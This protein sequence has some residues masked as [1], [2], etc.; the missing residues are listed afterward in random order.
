[1]VK[2]VIQQ[3]QVAEQSRSL[4]SLAHQ[5]AWRDRPQIAPG[6]DNA[7]ALQQPEVAAPVQV[8]SAVICTREHGKPE[9]CAADVR[10]VR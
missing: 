2:S 4:R 9:S 8:D 10:A 6:K 1:M 3:L 5:L 7:C